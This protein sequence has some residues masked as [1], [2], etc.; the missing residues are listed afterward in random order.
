MGVE[1]KIILPVLASILI[2]GGFG[3]T[4][5][6]AGDAEI[7][8]KA[9]G[10]PFKEL[11]EEIDNIETSNFNIDS[12]FDV[13]FDV[14][15]DSAGTET[16]NTIGPL[17]QIFG[18]PDFD[19]NYPGPGVAAIDSFF[20]IFVELDARDRHFDTEIVALQ[21]SSHEPIPIFG[22]PDFDHAA[23]FGDPDFDALF[24]DPD[25]LIDS[26]QSTNADLQ[27]QI[28]V[29]EQRIIALDERIDLIENPRP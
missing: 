9:Q 26:L 25:F 16:R 5:A 11:R 20:D 8:L 10:Q 21:L 7:T 22:D 1:G 27:R 19:T 12:F 24:G 2:F 4:D 29:L 3:F 14:T 17:T 15:T 13:F 23:L 6:F 28:D 18:D